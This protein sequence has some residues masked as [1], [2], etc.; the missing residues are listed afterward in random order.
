VSSHRRVS[1][2]SLAMPV[3]QN[4]IIIWE[5]QGKF[6]QSD[7]LLYLPTSY[8]QLRPHDASPGASISTDHTDKPTT[9]KRQAAITRFIS[10]CVRAGRLSEFSFTPA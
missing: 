4:G 9:A 7:E 3:S 5:T 2:P 6:N 10:R 1:F 8:C